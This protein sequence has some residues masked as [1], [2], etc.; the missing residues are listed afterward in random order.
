MMM[1]PLPDDLFCQHHEKNGL[2]L[3]KRCVNDENRLEDVRDLK[4]KTNKI[5]NV[6]FMRDNRTE[7]CYLSTITAGI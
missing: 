3:W 1:V 2:L 6:N 7:A 4:I 5:A